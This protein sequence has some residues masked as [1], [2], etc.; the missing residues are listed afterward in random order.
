MVS[1]SESAVL[2]SAWAGGC[3]PT[4]P[5][6]A[7]KWQ[8]IQVLSWPR[9]QLRL[10]ARKSAGCRFRACGYGRVEAP[11]PG[12]GRQQHWRVVGGGGAERGGAT[13]ERPSGCPPDDI[14]TTVHGGAG[15]GATESA[16]NGSC[17][18]GELPTGPMLARQ[19]S[20]SVHSLA[21]GHTQFS[22]PR[23]RTPPRRPV[24]CH[25]PMAA[26][27]RLTRLCRPRPPTH[28]RCASPWQHDRKAADICTAVPTKNVVQGYALSAEIAWRS[29]RASRILRMQQH[30]ATREP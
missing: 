1:A 17:G 11:P 27:S 19:R 29:E 22:R 6:R 24:R 18:C 15:R 8:Q 13:R 30:A 23:S 20:H 16:S 28:P 5:R 9:F 14:G 10:R 26:T 2:M 7:T 4:L 3:C 21:G 12:R 25:I